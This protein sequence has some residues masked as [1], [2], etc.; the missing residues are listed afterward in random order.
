[1]K[2]T[3]AKTIFV[4][5]AMFSI[6]TTAQADIIQGRVLDAETHEPLDG[7]HVEVTEEVPD[8]C[9][10]NWVR[11]TDSLGCFNYSCW[12]GSRITFRVRYLGYQTNVVRM[13]GTD[14]GDT[15]HIDDI[16]LKPSEVLLK[17]VLV[18]ARQRRFY[19]SGDTVVFN[20][21][22]F[23]M[24]DGDRL[25]DLIQKLPGVSIEENQLLWNGKPLKIRMNG[26]EALSE[27]LL[28][29]RLPVE[30]VSNVKA[31][32]RKSEL[33]E[34]TGVADGNQQQVLDVTIKP[35][36][37][38]K[39]YGSAEA[40]GYT[41]KY[42]GAQI[43]GMR[44]SDSDP[45]MLFGHVGDEPKRV[46]AR[47]MSGFARES[48]GTAV[49]QQMGA[50]GYKHAWRPSFD[51][52][53]DSYMTM[54]VGVNHT[55]RPQSNWQNTQTFLPG[56]THTQTNSQNSSY[57]HL[58]KAPLDFSAFLNLSPKNTL[59]LTAHAGYERGETYNHSQ[60]QTFESLSL[61]PINTSTFRSLSASKMFTGTIDGTFTHYTPKGSITTMASIGYTNTKE[62]GNSWGE[63]LY[64]HAA[65]A[66][67]PHQ[68][69]TYTD[70]QSYEAPHRHLNA[71][72]QFGLSHA[73]TKQ[74]MLQ[75]QW[76]TAYDY[77]F[78]DEQRLRADVIDLSNSFRKIEDQWLNALRTDA[79]LTLR[80]LSLKP[81]LSVSLLSQHVN[82]RRGNLDTIAKRNLLLLHPSLELTYRIRQQMS[83]KGTVQYVATPSQLIDCIAY[84]NDT[85]PLHIV[86]GNPSLITSH[87]L[88]ASL[89]YNFM[90]TRGSQAFNI[91]VNYGK[92]YDPIASVLHYNSQT[93]AYR[94]QKQNVRSGNN[95]GVELRYD[96][97][98]F[99]NLQ[100]QNTIA[101]R[102]NTSYGILTM[103]DEQTGLSYNR[104]KLSHLREKLGVIY[105]ADTWTISSFHELNWERYNLSPE[106]SPK[107]EGSEYAQDMK[108]EEEVMTP[109]YLVE[110]S[111][112]RLFRYSTELR[113]H[114]HL[115]HWNFTL[116][117]YFYLN[118]G[119]LSDT[120]NNNL[121]IL[122]AEV[123]YKFLRNNA[124]LILTALDLLNQETDYSAN[125]TA[126][127]HT[128]SGKSFLHHYLSLTFRYKL[129]QQ[130]R[131]RGN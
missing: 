101:E 20:P 59:F 127:T 50:V 115:N 96:R 57:E 49:R 5:I 8:L 119:Y 97:S 99:K 28:L 65:Q 79:N 98:L 117:P 100:F 56:T 33:E 87:T 88:N 11:Y 74:A 39:W 68:V 120:M 112:V 7:A 12:G 86:Q 26:K 60:Q 34:R 103:V 81:V 40:T 125:I 6:T 23:Q 80:K 13:M 58:F 93:G 54:T 71:T 63:Y 44:L 107:N 29:K 24:E 109:L 1:M 31:Y 78:R 43:D 10:V 21:G 108:T 123:S 73:I 62:H 9:T 47:T 82:Y 95:W 94:E 122:N 61:T 36:F 83:L 128:E 129:A 45:V 76:K 30:A 19:M 53:G 113:I 67:V 75:A 66:T 3:I 41:G 55:D 92:T 106:S 14:V 114:Y 104:Q 18:S 77:D 51:V 52:K 110:K 35:G 4:F 85:D 116:S 84:T 121:F 72:V 124:E 15:I 22:T 42:Y 130:K 17:E 70:H 105:E 118:R 90:L 25:L 32:E 91:A 38:D 89:R 2:R 111:R 102:W 46:M 69:E 37:M 48:G 126:T 27:D 16:L 64:H 131:H